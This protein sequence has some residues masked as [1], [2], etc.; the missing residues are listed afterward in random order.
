MQA[1]GSEKQCSYK[2]FLSVVMQVYVMRLHMNISCTTASLRAQI[3]NQ[4]TKLID[5]QK[6][7]NNNSH[8]FS[9]SY[10]EKKLHIHL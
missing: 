7:E 3:Q 9:K 10:F 8:R 4:C 5:R 6:F 1:H 2:M